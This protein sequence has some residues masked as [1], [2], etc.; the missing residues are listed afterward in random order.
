M[1]NYLLLFGSHYTISHI[2]LK[3]PHMALCCYEYMRVFLFLR[4]ASPL[5]ET[6]HRNLSQ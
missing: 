1:S 6:K 4:D 5:F 3:I 2:P